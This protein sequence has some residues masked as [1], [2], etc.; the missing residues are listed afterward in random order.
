MEIIRPNTNFDFLSKKVFFI[1]VSVLI[2]LV[3]IG[4]IVVHKGLNYGIDFA[5][6]TLMQLKFKEPADIGKIR[7][8]LKE[9]VGESVIQEY[10]SPDEVMIRVEQSKKGNQ[11]ADK[12]KK[13]LIQTF[14]K[15]SFIV[16][17]VGVVGPQVG[18]DL[19]E[20]AFFALLYAMLGVLIYITLRFEFRFAVGAIVA[21]VH[22]VLITVGVFS[23]L[24]KEFTLP[25]IAA[26]LTI[27]GYSLNDTIVVF[28]RIRERFA[29]KRK[30]SYEETINRSINETLSRT[31]L[32]SLTTLIVVIILL[33]LGGEVIHDFA[34][35][36]TVGIVVGTYSSIFIASPIL[37]IFQKFAKPARG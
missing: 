19:R 26:V 16:D 21:L 24:N 2:I 11:L 10:G 32:T 8:S 36:L 15:D 6:G 29:L 12:I 17:R 1:G 28:D 3:G 7:E 33:F 37:V 5:G 27:V 13:G 14:G 35:A 22:D 23:L 30:E 31:I 25:I 9:V 34:F 4:S 20:K 18:H